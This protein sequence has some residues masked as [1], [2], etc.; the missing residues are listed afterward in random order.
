MQHADK[1][2]LGDTKYQSI[3]ISLMIF[4]QYD[5]SKIRWNF[6]QKVKICNSF[7]VIPINIQFWIN[8]M[9]VN[10]MKDHKFSF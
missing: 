10:C 4:Y 2:L 3:L 5:A 1:Y 7:N 6:T 9:L 8:N